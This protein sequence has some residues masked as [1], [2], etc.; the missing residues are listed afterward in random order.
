[1]KMTSDDFERLHHV[2]TA[3]DT[4]ECRLGFST[5]A[6]SASDI[7]KRYRWDLYWLVW[8]EGFRFIGNYSDAHI[9]TALRK[10]VRPLGA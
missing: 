5:S 8:D 9:D 4:F 6:V 10:I 3:H 2:I 1:M 7:N